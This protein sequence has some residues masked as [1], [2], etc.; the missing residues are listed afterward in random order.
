MLTFNL[1]ALSVSKQ[2]PKAPSMYSVRQIS[3]L[4]TVSNYWGITLAPSDL[5]QVV[6]GA[7]L[8][9]LST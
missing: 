9:V 4:L 1:M 7:Y 5:G 3:L 2:I 8:D 6:V